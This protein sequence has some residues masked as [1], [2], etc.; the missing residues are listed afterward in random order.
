MPFLKIFV[1]FTSCFARGVLL[2]CENYGIVKQ[3]A[4]TAEEPKAGAADKCRRADLQK[5]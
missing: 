4:C 1:L 3:L 2:F 5:R